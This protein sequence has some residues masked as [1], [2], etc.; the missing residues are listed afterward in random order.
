MST[1]TDQ[2]YRMNDT[3]R[4]LYR[5]ARR[6]DALLAQGHR[7]Q[8]SQTDQY[9]VTVWDYM[10]GIRSDGAGQT[11]FVAVIDAQERMEA[12]RA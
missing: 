4:D 3:E 1:N 9:Y 12:A 2:L 6:I 7:V 5:A 11:M 8:F 10:N